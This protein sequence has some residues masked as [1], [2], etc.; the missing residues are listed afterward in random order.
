MK[1]SLSFYYGVMNSAKTATLLMQFHS[2]KDTQSPVLLKPSIDT[3]DGELNLRSRTGINRDVHFLICQQDN[4]CSLLEGYDT[5]HIFVDE[6]Q[7]LTVEQI[8][9]LRLLSLVTNVSCFGLKTDYRGRF[10]PASEHL[11]EIADKLKEIKTRC[12]Q[13]Y[14]K[15]IMTAKFTVVDGKKVYTKSVP[16]SRDNDC[17]T[18]VIDI[19]GDDKYQSLCW[20]CYTSV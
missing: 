18:N 3:R 7:F 13:C 11:F 12:S 15:A 16:P 9:Q 20:H 5:K 14:R 19:G 6:V 8:D 1:T 2:I 4:I 17:N 10:F